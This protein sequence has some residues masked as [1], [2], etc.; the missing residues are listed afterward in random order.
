MKKGQFE[1]GIYVM[2]RS[3]AEMGDFR[4]TGTKTMRRKPHTRRFKNWLYVADTKGRGKTYGY[5][6][7]GNAFMKIAVCEDNNI[8]S[9]Y[10]EDYISSLD[11]Q[12]I[13]YEIFSSGDD[14]IHYMEVE[15][16]TFNIYFMDIEMPGRNGIET[17][18]YIRSVDKN[19][20]IIFITDHKEYV[21]DVFDVLPFRF[22][23]KPVTQTS[24]NAVLKKAIEQIRT[25]KQVFFFK[26]NKN[27]LQVSFDEILYF[28][29]NRRKVKLVTA[30]KE[31]EFYG[32]ISELWEQLDANIFLQIHNSYVVNMEQIRQLSDSTVILKNEISLPISRHYRNPV[33]QR[34]LQYMEWRCE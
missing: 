7:E 27:R 5:A 31:Y 14:L 6:K 32:K 33:R 15:N 3:S 24:L 26:Q 34:H 2:P 18:A 19:A 1:Y 28:E 9:S 25:A 22:L 4:K 23:I 29:A 13:E 21:Y 10:M 8:V 17:S 11:L 12:D 16:A 30:E 20:L